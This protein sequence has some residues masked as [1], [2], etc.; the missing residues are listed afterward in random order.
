MEDVTSL[1]DVEVEN[2]MKQ[3]SDIDRKDYEDEIRKR[4]VLRTLPF[5]A[6]NE[7]SAD[8]RFIVKKI[9]TQLWVICVVLPVVAAL[10]YVALTMK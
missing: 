4:Q 3:A 9:T 6:R 1:I 2:L 5:D 8:A 10:L 7:V